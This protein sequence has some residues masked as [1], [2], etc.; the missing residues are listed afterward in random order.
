M[1]ISGCQDAVLRFRFEKRTHGDLKYGHLREGQE[2]REQEEACVP[3]VDND[4]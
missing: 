3:P 1:P 2:A 4:E